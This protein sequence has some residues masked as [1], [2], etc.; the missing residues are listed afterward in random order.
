LVTAIDHTMLGE[1]NIKDR[2]TTPAIPQASEITAFVDVRVI[3]M[4]SERELENQTVI[5]RGSRIAAIGPVDEMVVPEGAEIIEGNGAYLMP[6][7]ADMHMHIVSPEPSY[8]GPDQLRLFLAEG[9]TTIRNFSAMP[10]H[11]SWRDAV[12]RGDRVGP[13][14]YNG[15]LLV[16]LPPDL[17]S[18]QYIFRAIVVLGPAVIGLIAWLLAWVILMWTGNIT[19]FHRIDGYILPS[20]AVLLLVGILAAWLKIIPLNAYVSKFFPF[21]TVPENAK[22]ARRYVSDAKEAGYDFIK[23][24][25]YL[26]KDAYLA[27]ADEAGQQNMYVIGHLLDELSLEAIFGGGLREAAH[28]DEYMDWH[29]IGESSTRTGFNEAEFDY[30]TIP[31][32]A[33]TTRAFD[34]MVV[35]NMV[36]DETIYRLLEDPQSGLAEREYSSVP[37]EVMDVWHSRGRLVNWQGQQAWRRETMQP[38]LIAMTKAL[39][40]AGVP[41]L[42]GTDLTVEGMLPSHIHR[43]LELLVDAGLTPFEALEAG[44]KNAG[45][46]AERMGRDGN[47][48]T[49]GVGKR[50]D[51]ILLEQNPLEDVSH[52]RNR[53]GV[54]ARGRWFT[55]P[56][57]D[58]LVDEYVATYQA[59]D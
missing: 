8:K 2:A 7:L 40:D 15:K 21:A 46:S 3:P 1:V 49:V 11:M 14:I 56:E 24:Y 39:H 58:V 25:D 32:S 50:A 4:E 47:F 38:F 13:T 52:T 16:G 43:E 48:G 5:I 59:N 51:L 6:G 22:E 54:M 57:L 17:K 33:A 36:A 28:M 12:A 31:Q 53:I 30:Q 41:L 23:L 55:Q 42:L 34:V 44:T 45:I 35:S 9:V 37:P 19:Q 27:A 29:M 18:M 26:S 20:L 10:E